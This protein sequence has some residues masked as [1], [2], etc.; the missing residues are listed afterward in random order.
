[1]NETENIAL[2]EAVPAA[3]DGEFVVVEDELAEVYD[4]KTDVR[5]FHYAFYESGLWILVVTF[6]VLPNVE[7][8]ADSNI[9]NGT[10]DEPIDP[11]KPTA[12]QAPDKNE[13]LGIVEG[14]WKGTYQVAGDMLTLT[15][16]TQEVKVT[17]TRTFEE[18]A[19][20][21]EAKTEAELL[22]KFRMRLLDPFAK[23]FI[24]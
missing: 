6:D 11:N 22:D 16:E 18:I 9:G 1:M 14:I 21:T 10:Q 20:T 12:P 23:T 13:L 2:D 7:T 5:A 17:P 3:P 24:D 8:G 4:F 15:I 19:G